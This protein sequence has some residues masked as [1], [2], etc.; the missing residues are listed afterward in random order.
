MRMRKEGETKAYFL[1]LALFLGV[2]RSGTLEL[3]AMVG[4]FIS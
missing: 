4:K 2:S 3:Y 1:D